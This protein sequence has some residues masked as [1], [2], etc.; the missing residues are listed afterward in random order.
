MI[1]SS[2][3]FGKAW[4]DTTITE[5][6]ISAKMNFFPFGLLIIFMISFQNRYQSAERAAPC[7]FPSLIVE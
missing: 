5:R 1:A 2:L 3:E 7:M 6:K 4:R